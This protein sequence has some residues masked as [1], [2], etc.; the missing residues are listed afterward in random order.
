MKELQT[1]LF[2]GFSGQQKAMT[3]QWFA[4]LATG[5]AEVPLNRLNPADG[6]RGRQ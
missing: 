2:S 6:A 3:R 4:L 5:G 1:P